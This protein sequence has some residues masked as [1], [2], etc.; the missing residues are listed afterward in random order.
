MSFL[1]NSITSLFDN[2]IP[3]SDEVLHGEV[4]LLVV[5]G[6]ELQLLNIDLLKQVIDVNPLNSAG[7][8]PLELRVF[9]FELGVLL[10]QP[11]V[12]FGQLLLLDIE[13]LVLRIQLRVFD[14][15]LD[16]I[17]PIVG[18]GLRQGLQIH[19]QI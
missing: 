12:V 7:D 19:L 13:H 8:L 4:H 18:V 1:K 17:F 6:L 15:L 11:S 16:D 5:F 3:L 2:N 9:L 14:S 10:D